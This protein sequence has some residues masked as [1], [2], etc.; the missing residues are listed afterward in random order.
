MGAVHYSSHKIRDWLTHREITPV[1]P[2]KSN[3]KTLPLK[4]RIYR[5]RNVVERTIGWLKEHRRIATRYDKTKKNF[6]AFVKIAT[7]RKILKLI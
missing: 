5:K 4:R 3:E 6:L 1:I 2:T 7:A